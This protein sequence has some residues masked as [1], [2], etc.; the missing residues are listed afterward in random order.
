MENKNYEFHALGAYKEKIFDLIL[1]HDLSELLIDILMPTIKN[2]NFDK[3]ENFLGGKYRINGQQIIL[4]R[5]IFDVPFIYSTVTDTRGVICMDTNISGCSKSLK[6]MIIDI[7]VACHKNI[8]EID[9]DVR[10]KYFKLGYIGRNRVDIAI[11]IIGDILNDSDKFGIGK[12]VPAKYD[13]TQSLFPNR[14]FWEKILRYSCT[15][16]MKDY[17]KT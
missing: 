4:E 2:E 5:H 6:E 12:L 7:S 16:F 10:M 11:A 8:L 13:P 3:T 14:D 9:D 1:K 15:D 17:T